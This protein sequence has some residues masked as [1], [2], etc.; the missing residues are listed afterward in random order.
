MTQF[1]D[2]ERLAAESGDAAGLLRQWIEHRRALAGRLHDGC[3]QDLSILAL[4]IG[5]LRR[6]LDEAD[7]VALAL[8][9]L[10]AQATLV[11]EELRAVTIDLYPPALTTKGL[12]EALYAETRRHG[13][14]I[15]VSAAPGLSLPS[16]LEAG[17][18]FFCRAV[19]ATL[20]PVSEGGATIGVHGSVDT[21]GVVMDSPMEDG[22]ADALRSVV[23]PLVI[24]A[25]GSCA[26]S[27]SE[28]RLLLTASWPI[29]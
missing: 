6:S 4:E 10:A 25:G 13:F 27:L 9:E 5:R 8:G 15:E 18:F 14:P 2:S 17:I 11:Q 23:Q 7:P 1:D 24:A 20:G 12:V 28:E 29:R 19:L 16:H 21:V 26:L 3:Q 22:L